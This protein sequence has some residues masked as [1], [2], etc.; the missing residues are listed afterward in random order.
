MYK[1]LWISFY[2]KKVE[3]KKMTLDHLLEILLKKDKR[4]AFYYPNYIWI[5]SLKIRIEVLISLGSEGVHYGLI[6]PVEKHHKVLGNVLIKVAS[7]KNANSIEGSDVLNLSDSELV[8]LLDDFN[9]L[10]IF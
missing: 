3:K 10:F 5:E 7:S 6:V 8:K 1:H 9:S 4:I 2:C